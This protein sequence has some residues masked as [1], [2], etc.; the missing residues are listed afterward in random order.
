[1]I[2]AEKWYEYQ[3][4]YKRY[5]LDMKPEEKK[6]YKP[7]SKSIVSAKDRFRLLLLTVIAGILCVGLIIS[8]AYA[9][10]LKYD[11]N[12]IISENAVIE[13]EIQ[14]LNVKIKQESNITTIEEKAMTELGMV[15][16]TGNQVVYLEEEKE[17][18]KDFA[19]LLKEQAYN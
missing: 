10:Q 2:A 12:T 9:A 13:G 15:Y 18:A 8:T 11:I 3:D 4:S 14:N 19:V 7:K 16:P 1:M 5:G 6:H 17:I